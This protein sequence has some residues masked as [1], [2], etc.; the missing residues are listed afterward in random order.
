VLCVCVYV[1][2]CAVVVW[3]CGGV[4]VSPHHVGVGAQLFSTPAGQAEI[5][6]FDCC[7][8]IVLAS[9]IMKRNG[10]CSAAR[11]VAEVERKCA[12]K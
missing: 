11:W 8:C 3:W 12:A 6:I 7:G 2:V 1:C 4:G 10:G 5:V 9:R